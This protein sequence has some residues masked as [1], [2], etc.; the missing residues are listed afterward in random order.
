[1]LRVLVSAYA[2]EPEKGSE[3]GIGWNWVRQI[4]ASHDVWAITRAN[5]R[6]AIEIALAK[7]PLPSVRF[8]YFDLPAW[9]RFWKR[10]GYGVRLYYYLWQLGALSVARKLHRHVDFDL[11]HHVTL[12][13]YW[14][15]CF[16]A[17]LPV[18]FVLGPVGG[19][20]SAP[21]GFWRSFSAR[22]K[23]YEILRNVGRS[24]GQLDPFVRLAARR[25]TVALATTEQTAEKLRQLGCRHI[26]VLSQVALSSDEIL[27]SPGPPAY[28]SGHFRVLS[29]GRFL[30]WKGFELGLRAFAQ[31]RDRLPAS[32]YWLIGDGPE[33]RRLIALTRKLGLA[34]RVYFL[35]SMPRTEVAGRM[36][37]CDVLL[38]PSLHDSGSFVCA[39]AMCV[40]L[41]VICLDVGGPALIVTQQTGI[42]IAAASPEQVIRDLAK[43]M[44][45]LGGDPLGRERLGKSARKHV[46]ESF[47]WER[48][49]EF[50]SSTYNRVAGRCDV[51]GSSQTPTLSNS[52]C[53]L[54]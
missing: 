6:E 19:G 34:D 14:A 52:D 21:R 10:R 12:G 4:A 49:G 28:H 26:S 36:V 53:E 24:F 54:M 2:C 35:G 11:V 39:E 45:R 22:G 40:G 18:P 48:K 3:P 46:R 29:V 17:T 8:V 13:K 15:P 31:C 1:M 20:E 51:Y 16:L 32:E 7:H 42:K 25:A 43:A 9:T 33:K 41:P 27:Q 50:I 5:N 47:V 38:N 44:I 30:H 37:E 23:I